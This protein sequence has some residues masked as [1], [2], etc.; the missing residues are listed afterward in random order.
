MSNRQ[1]LEQAIAVQENLRGMIDDAIIDATIAALRAQLATLEPPSPAGP[2]SRRAQATILFLDLA[3]HTELIQGWDAEEIMEIIDRALQRLAEPI[4]RHGGRI[5]RYQGD[6]FK[7]VFGLPT[8]QEH[9]PDHAVLAGL[10]MLATA[11]TIAAELE[12][13]CGLAGFQARIGI[14]TGPVL[15][16]GGTEGEDAVT[17]LPVNLAARLESAAEPGTILISHHTYQH[18]RGVFDFQPL[19]PIT[20]K[21]F[22]EPVAVYRVLRRKA[23]SFRTRRRGVEGVETRMIGR[24]TELG[25]L[26]AMFR[27]VI[28]TGAHQSALVVGEAGLGKSRLLYEFENWVDLQPVDVQLYRGR[29]W[30]ETQNLPYGLMRNVFVFRCGIH[31][32][33][34]ADVV[35]DKLVDAFHSIMGPDEESTRKAHLVGHLLGYDFSAGP[36]VPAFGDDAR[37]LRS[38]AMF[39]LTEFFKSVAERGPILFLI[40]DL[41]WA[42]D[43][44]LD[45]IAALV[46]AEAVRPALIVSAARP[47]LFE[48]R[49]G[50][51]K[52][53]PEHRRIDLPSLGAAASDQLVNEILQK[54]EQIPDRLRQLLISRSEG[55][56]YY[57][58]ELVKMLIDEGVIVVGE[59][60]WRVALERMDAVRVPATLTGVLQARLESLPA[61][62]RDTLQRASVVGRLFWNGAVAYVGS[63]KDE[64]AFDKVAPAL[65]RRELVY[66]RE[67]SAFEGTH[68]YVFKHALLRDVT[69]ES[70]LR[71]LRRTYH[72]RAAEWI[73]GMAGGRLDEYADQIAGHFAA[74]GDRLAEAEWQGRAGRQAARRYATT[75]ALYALS[76]ALELTPPEELAA[77]YDLFRQRG[78]VFHLQG[79]RASEAADLEEMERL[80]SQMEDAGRR[81]QAAVA[82]GTYYLSTGQYDEVVLAGDEAL[83]L[84][85][86]A[87]DASLQARIYNNRGH[88]LVY[89]GRYEEAQHSLARA[90]ELA[91][92]SGD[93]RAHIDTL[94]ILG[95]FAEDQGDFVAEQQYFEE[96]LRLSREVGDRTGERRALNSLGVVAQNVG[97]YATAVARYTES[98][99]IARA[100]GDRVGEGTVLGNLGVQANHVGDYSRACRMFEQSL[101]ID[102]ET[103]NK[104]GVSVNLLNLAAAAAYMEDYEASLDYYQQSLP[105]V[106]ETGDKPLLGYIL[107]GQ[108]LTLLSAG[109]TAEAVAT[110]RQGRDLRLSLGQPHLAAETRAFLA[111]ALAQNG[112]VGPAVAEVEAVLAFLA[113]GQLLEE[114]GLSRVML[115]VYR[116]LET[117]GDARAPGVL[118][119]AYADLQDA[120]ARLDELSRHSFLHNVAANREIVALWQAAGPA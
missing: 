29:A 83:G 48:R 62:E 43:S 86:P 114:A 81:A 77:R 64:G 84:S 31:D 45:A 80:A 70:V 102:R 98:L 116:V 53:R 24:E 71:R 104:T 39:Y 94:R 44:S 12:A 67:A 7:A 20:A 50:W 69:Y 74:A 107:N 3:G 63:E 61:A 96:A 5:V 8:A 72:R 23:R 16:G 75:E 1:Q 32:D 40:E 68:E 87:F 6:G 36:Y 89:L 15:L 118:A 99:T 26:Q 66:Q 47:G 51:L 108:G 17:G 119:R 111:E 19:A 109:R 117:A 25:A 97:D 49:P 58:E 57:V 33:D 55:N 30:L 54:A 37:Q 113:E 90:L 65:Q 79:N 100:T 93:K 82:K 4:G 34:P 103:G 106:E 35:R 92:V 88:A 11:A 27:A 120:A 21:G 59:E 60:R 105:G 46:A 78:E 10:D 101:E 95:I 9:D 73:I 38:Q 2:E 115:A 76:R 91:Q 14:D 110:L 42:D 85:D 56:P 52:D 41:H 13:E 112:E 22:A 28:E 18:I